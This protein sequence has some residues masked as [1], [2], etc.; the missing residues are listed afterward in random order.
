MNAI[1]DRSAPGVRITLLADERAASGEP[2]D[3]GD[4]LIGFTFE[5]GIG[6]ANAVTTQSLT[7]AAPCHPRPG[8]SQP[9]AAVLQP[10]LERPVVDPQASR[11]CVHAVLAGQRDGFV[12]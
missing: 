6:P 1:L 4:Q 11:D 12:P 9:S 7:P 2:L 8:P 10:A 3:L 5:E